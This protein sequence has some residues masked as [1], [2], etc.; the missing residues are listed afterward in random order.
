MAWCL[1]RHREKFTFTS[2]WIYI[3]TPLK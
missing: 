2:S 3:Q 1:N